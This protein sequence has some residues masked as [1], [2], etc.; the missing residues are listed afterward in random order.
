MQCEF[1]S[2]ARSVCVSYPNSTIIASHL[3]LV[4]Y[5]HW[6]VNDPRGSGSINFVDLKFAPLGPIHLGRKPDDQ[7][8]SRETLREFHERH[9]ELLNFP[10]IWIDH[11]IR[12][13]I[14]EAIA[15]VVRTHQYSCYACGIC[16]NHLHIVIRKHKHDPLLIWTN[17]AEGIKERLRIR[18][19]NRINSNHPVI[20]A[21]PYKVYLYTPR[22]VWIRIDYANTDPQKEGLPEQQWPFVT[23]YDNWPLH[24]TLGTTRE[25]ALR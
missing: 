11:D 12:I 4:L 24:K 1:A 3:I 6:A 18:F 15:D 20:S 13:E 7:Q 10:I 14:A 17:L 22:E 19:A 9:Q 16:A 5:G 21:R 23:F 2:V 8:P 25:A